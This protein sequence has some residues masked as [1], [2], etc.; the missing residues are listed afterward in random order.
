MVNQLAV[1]DKV[2]TEHHSIR[3]NIRFVSDSLSDVE[4][5]F[6]LHKAHADLA[7][8]SIKDLSSKRL[9]LQRALNQIDEG[10]RKH[11]IYEEKSLE[12]LFGE[13]LIRALQHE[14]RKIIEQIEE[15]KEIVAETKPERLDQRGKLSSR[16][17]MQQAVS[18]ICQ[19][20]EQHANL[21]EQI[22]RMLRRSLED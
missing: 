18:S 13:A 8:A 22:L 15:A 9:Q 12:S 3:D 11:F 17:G 1:I 16:S 10:L 4:A 14:H 5:L 2:I 19:S 6:S 20:V 21:E 7:Q